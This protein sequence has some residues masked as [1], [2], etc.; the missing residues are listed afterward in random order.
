MAIVQLDEGPKLTTQLVGL[1]QE[2]EAGMKVRAV[3]RKIAEEG[4]EGVIY[5]GYKFAPA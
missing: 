4:A 1:D 5:Y 3:F 2:P